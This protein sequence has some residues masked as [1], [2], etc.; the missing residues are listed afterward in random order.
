MSRA[1]SQLHSLASA[2]S[3]PSDCLPPEADYPSRDALFS[4]INA[5][6]V[7][8]VYAFT[9]ESQQRRGAGNGLSR[10]RAIDLADRQVRPQSENPRRQ[11]VEP[12]VLSP[13]WLR[14]HST[15]RPGLFDIG[16]TRVF[17][18][19]IMSQVSAQR[20]TQSIANSMMRT[21]LCL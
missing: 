6:A 19:I 13:F 9:L 7:T 16:K 4:S 5:W 1:M 3:F 8:R 20:L 14:N 18:C 12:I 17:R 11:V 15:K 2:A 10:T 21:L